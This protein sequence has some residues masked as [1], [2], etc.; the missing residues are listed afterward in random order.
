MDA[1]V[2]KLDS[3]TNPIGSPA[4]YHN[5]SLGRWSNLIFA[6][7]GRIVVRRLRFKL[8]GA[9]IHGF[10]CRFNPGRLAP[11]SYLC[12]GGTTNTC[13]LAIREPELLCLINQP[14]RCFR[15]WLSRRPVLKF[16][17][18]FH[19]EVDNLF[20]VIKKERIDFRIGVN[21]FNAHPLPQRLFDVKNPFD[22]RHGEFLIEFGKR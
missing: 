6:G 9:G 7:I 1:A 19:L 16:F 2:I 22:V 8:G 13:E 18:K 3:L 20:D 15:H 21:L 14:P 11:R 12:L 5:L 4:Q 10:K 17:F